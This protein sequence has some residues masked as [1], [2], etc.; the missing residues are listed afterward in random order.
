[1]SATPKPVE[2]YAVG[3]L[4]DL[5]RDWR[6]VMKLRKRPVHMRRC[7]RYIA[8]QVR[9]RNWRAVKNSFNGY[10]AEP[11]DMSGVTRC[12]T[13]WTKRRAM[14]SLRRQYA[15]VGLRMPEEVSATEG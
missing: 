4:A 10:L 7:L 9:A 12:G 3:V 8:R 6:M 11:Y 5:K 15:V 14:R 1:M 13:G 2:V